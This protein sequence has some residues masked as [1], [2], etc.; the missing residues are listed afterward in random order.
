MSH[1]PD[2]ASDGLS[3]VLAKLGLNAKVFLRADL[4]GRWGID[5]S[6]SR[7][8][9][10]HFME[11]GRGWL[12]T[13][14]A[15]EPRLLEPG[16]FVIFPHDMAHCISSDPVRPPTELVNRLPTELAGEIT[17][18]LCGFFEFH[19]PSAWPLLESLP[20]V[21]VLA[22]DQ[23]GEIS[24]LESLVELTIGEL[25]RNE[26]G[27][28]A[29]LNQ[30][31]LLLFVHILRSQIRSGVSDGLLSALADRQIGQSLN[32]IHSDFRADWSVEEL[33]RR[34]GMSRSA[35]SEK[36]SRLVGRPPMRY[37]AEW[38]M[39][40]ALES[41]RA[42]DASV[43]SIA[44]DV[45]YESEMAFR[46]AFRNIMGVTPGAARRGNPQHPA[47]GRRVDYPSAASSSG[48]TLKRSP[49]MP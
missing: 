16:D 20:E 18:V 47:K 31:A 5:T 40:E 48:R 3:A 1:L 34:V 37:L 21:M 29:A 41:L 30:L 42:G 4:C 28:S 6:G 45:G 26:P 23:R 43:A 13:G 49:T 17:S 15:E 24:A 25:K 2:T 35:F 32:L 39:H 9:S 44:A 33:A 38:R 10:F 7:K 46:K 36:F 11:R 19:N 27:M 14:A 8:A 22:R 12:H